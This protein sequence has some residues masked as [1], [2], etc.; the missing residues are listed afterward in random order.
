MRSSQLC[1][2]LRW[3]WVLAFT[4]LAASVFIPAQALANPKDRLG[5]KVED[6]TLRTLTGE[7]VQ[8]LSFL[9]DKPLVIAY[10]GLGCPIS[11]RYAP[12]LEAIQKEFSAK[13]VNLIGINANPQDKPEAIAKEIK[14]LGITFP[15]L[16]DSEQSLTKQLDAQTSTIAFVV[17]KEGVLRYRGMIDDQ[18]AVGAQKEKP[19]NKYLERAIRSVLASKEPDPAKTVAPGCLIT[20]LESKKSDEK[21]TY[22]SHIARIIQDHCQSC[23]RPQQIA[24]FALTSYEAVQGWSAMIHSVVKGGRMPPWNAHGDYDGLFVNERKLP[25]S[26]K[27][28]LLAWIQDGMPRGTPEEDPPAKKWPDQWRIGKPDK[29]YSMREAF[30]VPAEGVVPYQFFFIPTDFRKDMWI[31]AVEIH[32]GAADVVHHVIA[33]TVDPNKRVDN[34]RLGLEDGFLCA[35]VP[36]DTPSIFAPGRGKKLGAGHTLVLQVHY[37][38]NGK[39][40]KDK[41]QIGLI[42]AKE[43]VTEEVRT[44]GIFN[45]NF[46]IPP[47]DSNY[48]VLS[49]HTFADDTDLLSFY[50]HMHFRGK[51]WDYVATFPDQTKKT[52][53]SVPKYNYNWQESYILKEPM[54]L[55]AGTKLECIAHYDN[56]ADNFVNPDPTKAV[57]FGEQSWDEMMIGYVDYVVPAQN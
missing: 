4:F 17:D 32:A 2:I 23:H 18:Y 3:I 33:F 12:R 31:Q 16:Q 43:P 57:R 10:T 28:L 35:T 30:E 5:E 8:L 54:R 38:A 40:R 20:R 56:S 42:F 49:E 36:G 39:K 25:E 9:K 50:P 41:S 21:V 44:R 22:S 45:L 1:S 15:V 24:P 29:V 51:S 37:T 19:S 27:K 11:G 13:G 55:P 47:G 7:S 52:L 6:V 53:L 14:E 34:S 46:T 48:Q 26:D